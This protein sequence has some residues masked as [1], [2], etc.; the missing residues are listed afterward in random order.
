MLVEVVGCVINLRFR[1]LDERPV[2]RQQG[3]LFFHLLHGRR[4]WSVP[5]GD[6]HVLS[7]RNDVVLQKQNLT[8]ASR[9]L[10]RLSPDT[11]SRVFA[12]TLPRGSK[13]LQF[14]TQGEKV[15]SLHGASYTRLFD[16]DLL[17]TVQEFAVD[18]EFRI[19]PDT[20]TL[21]TRTQI[22]FR[23]RKNHDT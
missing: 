1:H 13:P 10:Y 8:L 19:I 9:E 11:A 22:G 16:V 5:R 15:R 2:V 3:F 12:E 17:T 20:M 23:L 7:E 6:G 14:F 4:A 18:S 21:M